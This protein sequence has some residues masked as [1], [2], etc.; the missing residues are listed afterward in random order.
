MPTKN[1]VTKT[2]FIKLYEPKNPLTLKGVS[3][4]IGIRPLNDVA[5]TKDS[6]GEKISL[7][8]L[9]IDDI[10][11]SEFTT[12]EAPGPPELPAPRPSKPLEPKNKPLEPIL[13]PSEEPIKPMDSSDPDEIQLDLVTSLY[14][15]VKAKIF[16][17]KFD[18]NSSTPNTYKQALKSPNVKEWLA[19]TFSE[20]EQ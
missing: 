7:D 3:K 5:I 16:K 18:K 17:K 19:A 11:S 2:P 15:R 6:T 13:R 12:P 1:I 20:F 9:E 10:G 8:L 4:P 14:Y